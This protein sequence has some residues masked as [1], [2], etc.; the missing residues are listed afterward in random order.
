M[1]NQA[2]DGMAW[3][4]IAASA[5]RAYAANT[6]NKNFQ[7]NPMPTWDE[8]PRRIQIAWEAAVRQA[9]LGVPVPSIELDEQRW[10][11]WVPPGEPTD[12]R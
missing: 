6:G 10:A 3:R 5:Y 1:S 11:G 9:S 8:L 7:G 2:R 4:D 12:D